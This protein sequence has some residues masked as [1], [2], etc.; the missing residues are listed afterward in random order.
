MY[1][2]FEALTNTSGDSLAGYFA[3][4]VDRTTLAAV[5]LY[6]DE[7]GT[8]I[9]TVSGYAD[10]AKTDDYGNLDFYLAPGTYHLDIYAP[11]AVTFRFRV[12]NVGMTSTQGEQGI[13]GPVGDPG[14]AFATFATLAAFK[15]GP[16]TNKIQVLQ[17]PS[18]AFGQFNWETANAPYTAD[19]VNIIKADSTALS[20]GA[21]VRQGAVT[22]QTKGQGSSA[23]T[24]NL[25]DIARDFVFIET[26][27]TSDV[28]ASL[29]AA[30]AISKT[31]YLG[32]GASYVFARAP[33]IPA[34]VTIV[35]NEA[36]ISFSASFP[37]NHGIFLSGGNKLLG[38]AYIDGTNLPAPSSTW[39][40]ATVSPPG[41]AIYAGANT[42][43]AVSPRARVEIEAW[44]ITN[45]PSG[46]IFARYTPVTTG[47]GCR[48]YDNQ[49][50]TIMWKASGSYVGINTTNAGTS[51]A[52]S[53]ALVTAAVVET[54]FSDDVV[55]H[56]EFT[57]IRSKG[58]N[59]GN[60]KNPIVTDCVFKG[61]TPEHCMA[62]FT[63]CTGGVFGSNTLD[64][65]VNW[66]FGYK[67]DLSDGMAF[68]PSAMQNVSTGYMFQS[69]T[70]MSGSTG[71]ITEFLNYAYLFAIYSNAPANMTGMVFSPGLSKTTQSGA[72]HVVLMTDAGAVAASKIMDG[73]TIQGGVFVGGAFGFNHASSG[74]SPIVRNVRIVG[75]ALFRDLTSFGVNML[76]KSGGI[77]AEFISC[78]APFSLGSIT[79][80]AGDSFDGKIV[81]TGCSSV[82]ARIGATS[83]LVFNQISL[84]VKAYG[85]GTRAVQAILDNSG[86]TDRLKLFN[87]SVDATDLT[88][89]TANVYLDMN[90]LAVKGRVDLNLFDT[91]TSTLNNVT[92]ANAASLTGKLIANAGITGTHGMTVI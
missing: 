22:I 43:S 54:Y 42:I 48:F 11:D 90:S 60:G 84:S 57:G 53:G 13:Q 16:I 86:A 12:S 9:I 23:R 50:S 32:K 47:R 91:A 39:A 31:V 69:S 49:T 65:G 4:V 46:A 17:D 38:R 8:P 85:G 44:Q 76:L 75:R 7:S 21:W 25:E 79:G 58:T 83:D 19:N 71:T 64:G 61:A 28:A 35:G 67:C 27:L 66:G 89:R 70:N 88:D 73:I 29:E 18:I 87:L 20:I 24:R 3:R 92:F 68:L 41:T 37:D 62:H 80:V 36:L 5:T 34:G 78:A 51:S 81:A 59:V 15:A 55:L 40:G 2:Y 30:C 26:Y 6:S 52:P 1:H 45:C 10:L 77:D 74:V 14:P 72:G 56:G 63:G 33:V 82:I